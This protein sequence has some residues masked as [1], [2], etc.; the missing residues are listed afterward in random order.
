MGQIKIELIKKITLTDENDR[1]LACQTDIAATLISAN[2][3]EN[4]AIYYFSAFLAFSEG[5]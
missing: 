3:I 4:L 2:V 1:T 5:L